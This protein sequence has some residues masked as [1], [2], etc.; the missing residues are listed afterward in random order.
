MR[1]RSSRPRKA[2]DDREGAGQTRRLEE[3]F[4]RSFHHPPRDPRSAR[5]RHLDSLLLSAVGMKMLEEGGT[6]SMRQCPRRSGLPRPGRLTGREC[7]SLPSRAER[8]YSRCVSVHGA[9]E[10]SDNRPDCQ[11]LRSRLRFHTRPERHAAPHDGNRQEAAD[12]KPGMVRSTGSVARCRSAYVAPQLRHPL[13]EDGTDIRVIR[14]LLG[15]PK[16]DNTAFYTKVAT[17]TVRTV[18]SP[19]GRPDRHHRRAPFEPRE[20]AAPTAL[21]AS[22]EKAP[23]RLALR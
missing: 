4:R 12:G 21:V 20:R 15:H 11:R 23:T 16:L 9:S 14:V 2:C 8:S 1:A 3:Q 22:K 17:R 5:R 18:T 7:A 19:L 6:R 13:L 10:G